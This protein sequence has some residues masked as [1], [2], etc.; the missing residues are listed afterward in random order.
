MRWVRLILRNYFRTSDGYLYFPDSEVGIDSTVI[1]VNI[2][3]KVFGAIIEIWNKA[4]HKS[5]KY[6][7]DNSMFI[8]DM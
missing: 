1:V 6:L 8:P 3:R 2:Q 5:N 7:N 4:Q